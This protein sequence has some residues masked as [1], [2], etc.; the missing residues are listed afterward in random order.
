[1]ICCPENSGNSL[2]IVSFVK[3]PLSRI[4]PQEEKSRK[5]NAPYAP[6][7]G[8]TG[9]GFST[10]I[11]SEGSNTKHKCSYLRREIITVP[12]LPIPLKSARLQAP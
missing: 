5:R 4:V 6:S 11:L 10:A 3:K 9:T 2:N 1:M 8:A 7:T 12:A